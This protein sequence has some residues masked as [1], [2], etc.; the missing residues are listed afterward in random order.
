VIAV[1]V[2]VSGSMSE[3]VGRQRRIDVLADILRDVFAAGARLFAFAGTVHEIEPSGTL[4]EPGGGTALDQALDHVALLA[5]KR[6]IVISDGE[7]DD[8]GAA[9]VA[10]RRLHCEIVTYYAGDERDHAAIAFLR[11]LA[12]CSADGLGHAVVSDL[13]DPPKLV[14]ELKLRLT[15]PA[16]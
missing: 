12:W 7:P 8:R 14:A 15:G 3:P 4:P 9:L 2:D 11:A 10:A 1:L 5:P 6:V 16:R 13:R